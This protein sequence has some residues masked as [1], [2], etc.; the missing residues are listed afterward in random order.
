MTGENFKRLNRG[1]DIKEIKEK[2]L[3]LENECGKLYNECRNTGIFDSAKHDKLSK[4]I[5]WQKYILW[6]L[7][8]G[9]IID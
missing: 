9:M 3:S 4:E 2:I 1:S 7:Q 5:E 8:N 6:G